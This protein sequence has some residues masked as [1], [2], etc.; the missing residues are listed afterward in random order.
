ME[1]EIYTKTKFLYL[2][3]LWIERRESR[4]EL[5]LNLLVIFFTPLYIVVFISLQLLSSFFKTFDDR[6]IY[7]F[8]QIVLNTLPLWSISFKSFELSRQFFLKMLWK[9][10]KRWNKN[11]MVKSPTIGNALLW[12]SDTKENCRK[13]L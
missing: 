10:K 7:M 3:P 11:L 8:E 1:F 2:K 5:S 4:M 9:E 12:R 6:R 13:V